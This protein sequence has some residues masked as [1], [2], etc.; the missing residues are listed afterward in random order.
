MQDRIRTLFVKVVRI[1]TVVKPAQM[2]GVVLQ[3][4]HVLVLKIMFVVTGQDL[5]VLHV[6]IMKI[7]DFGQ[8]LSVMNVLLVIKDDR[9]HNR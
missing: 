3:M 5:L 4:E 6:P 2:G 1:V 8:E 7:K 9:A